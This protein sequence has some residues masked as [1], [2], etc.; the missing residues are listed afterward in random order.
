MQIITRTVGSLD[1]NCYL[2]ADAQGHALC[3]D[4]GAEADR[5]LQTIREHGMQIGAVV[6][7]HTHYDHMGAVEAV[8]EATGAPLWVPREDAPG[9]ADT[10]RN[11]SAA[12]AEP[13]TV[14]PAERLLDEGDVL[15][16]GDL[17]LTV[18]HTP[19]HTCGSCS[20]ICEAE[21]VVFTGDTL[22]DHAYGRTDFPGG[23]ALAIRHS[24]RR[25]KQELAGY[26]AYAGHGASFTI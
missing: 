11:L 10:A 24:L 2:A 6:L 25:L 7:T 20:L 12:Y 1:T 15:R 23:S 19:G 16:C 18:W 5:I 13:L 17:T 26:T 21:R 22:F 9:L 3:I 8:R 14:R 4:P